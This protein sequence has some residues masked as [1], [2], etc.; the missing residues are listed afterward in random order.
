MDL[1]LASQEHCTQLKDSPLQRSYLKFQ[2]EL[3]QE[4]SSNQ[5]LFLT[6]HRKAAVEA[7]M[8]EAWS[9][10]SF[11]KKIAERAKRASLNDFDR[12]KCMI[13]RKQ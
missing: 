9:S 6:L 5:F 10:L 11:A 12:F 7:K 13:A 4:K 3:E 1:Q 8:D 2:E